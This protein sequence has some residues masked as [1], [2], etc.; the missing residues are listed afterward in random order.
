MGFKKNLLIFLFIN[1]ILLV[2]AGIGIFRHRHTPAPA[3]DRTAVQDTANVQVPCIGNIQVL[4]GCSGE[5]AAAKVRDFLRSKNFDVKNTGN[6]ASFNYPFTFV[7]AR[8]KDMTIA[9]NIAKALKTNHLVLIRSEDQPYDATVV[10][11]PDY[12]ERIK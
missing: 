6:A 3:I 9:R 10:I 1:S 5:G 4:N 11:G 7:I 8:K 2:A 12:G